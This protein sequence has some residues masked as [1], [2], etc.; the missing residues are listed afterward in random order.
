MSAFERAG[1]ALPPHKARKQVSGHEFHSCRTLGLKTGLQ[2]LR[3]P[4]RVQRLATVCEV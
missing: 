3:R 1:I 2:P 4:A